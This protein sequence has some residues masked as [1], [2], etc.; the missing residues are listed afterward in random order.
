MQREIIHIAYPNIAYTICRHKEQFVEELIPEHLL[1]HIVSG[2]LHIKEA[3]GG[4]L[5]RAGET[6]LFRRNHLVKCGSHPL[7]GGTPNEVFYFTLDRQVLQDYAL[8]HHRK[9]ADAVSGYP[10]IFSLQVSPA[11]KSLFDSLVPYI[12]SDKPLS[13][14]MKRHKLEE[15]IHIL[16]EQELSLEQCLF[17]FADPGRTDLREFMLR[18]YMFNIPINKFAELTGRSL[19][20]FQRDFFKIFGMNASHW[21]LKQRLQAA[22]EALTSGHKRPSDIYLEFGFGDMSHFSKV[23]KSEYGYSPSFLTQKKPPLSAV[24]RQSGPH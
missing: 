20:T 11:L 14:V 23:F 8:K 13:E 15:A 2:E 5:Y 6:I 16:L 19:S 22:H 10:G 4:K 24:H 1:L 7:P 12:K 3:T 21:L 17:D 18:N 9:K